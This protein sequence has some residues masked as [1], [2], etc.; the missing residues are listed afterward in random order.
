MGIKSYNLFSIRFHNIWTEMKKN[1][2]L[3]ILFI[4]MSISCSRLDIAAKFAGTYV[5]YKADD[6]FD[7]NSTQ[8]NWLRAEFEKDFLKIK[9]QIIPNVSVELSR[10]SRKVQEKKVFNDQDL[11]IE[12]EKLNDFFYES[13]K[14]FSKS[15]II[16]AGQ[17]SPEQIKYFQNKFEEGLLDFKKNYSQKSYSKKLKSSF[18][19]WFDDLTDSQEEKIEEFVLNNPLPIEQIISQ[20][21]KLNSDFREAYLRD[22]KRDVFIEKLFNDYNSL[23]EKNY[24]DAR[25][26]RN[27]KLIKLVVNVLNTMTEEQRQDLSNALKLK[28]EQLVK[29]N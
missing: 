14:L 18:N 5:V 7:L 3:F 20:R 17:L 27:N 19:N 4:V 13:I 16:F 9:N 2:A 12:F 8:K 11:W 23:L 1:P 15:A 26:E 24:K 21:K 28:A 22:D 10:L 6:Y 25:K 29:I